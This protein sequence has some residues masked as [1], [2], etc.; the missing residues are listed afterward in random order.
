VVI[1]ALLGLGGLLVVRAV[2]PGQTDATFFNPIATPTATPAPATSPAATP[3]PL[4]GAEIGRCPQAGDGR[5]GTDPLVP[6]LPAPS[7][8]PES[9]PTQPHMQVCPAIG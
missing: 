9:S 8:R 2:D 7:P 1:V 4:P 5:I 3:A 6:P